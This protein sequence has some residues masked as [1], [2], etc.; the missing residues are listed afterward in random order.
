VDLT[1]ARTGNVSAIVERIT[2][3]L[4]KS[5]EEKC[6]GPIFW[7]AKNMVLKPRRSRGVFDGFADPE[8][9]YLEELDAMIKTGAFARLSKVSKEV[10]SISFSENFLQSLII[11]P[12]IEQTLKLVEGFWPVIM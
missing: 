8:H 2:K 12:A 1:A 11:G 3:D 9:D 10:T 7:S 6:V 4:Q 5:I